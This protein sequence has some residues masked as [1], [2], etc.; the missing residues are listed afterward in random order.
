MVDRLR[1]RAA[2]R[3]ERGRVAAGRVG[4][5]FVPGA[6]AEVGLERGEEG[7]VVEPRPLRIGELVEP[8]AEL[9]RGLPRKCCRHLVEQARPRADHSPE[10]DVVFGKPRQRVEPAIIDEPRIAEIVERDHQRIARERGERLVGRVAVAG[11]PE[12]EHLPETLRH[13]RETV[14]PAMR[15]RADLTDAVPA[16][17]RGGMKQDAGGTTAGGR[18]VSHARAL[19][20]SFSLPVM[21]RPA[22]CGRQCNQQVRWGGAAG[23]PRGCGTC[24]T[25]PAGTAASGR[26]IRRPLAPRPLPWERS[27]G[28]PPSADRRPAG[29]WQVRPPCPGP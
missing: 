21:T 12:R 17:K 29:P 27:R 26:P 18:R 2:G 1:E 6:A 9:G 11:R 10:V 23:M 28:R 20:Q 7:V 8:L 25:G 16:G 19:G 13:A 14:E 5:P 4:G 3:G 15:L 22:S 24:F